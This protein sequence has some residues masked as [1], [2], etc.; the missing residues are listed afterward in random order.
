MRTSIFL[1]AIADS[2]YVNIV[3]LLQAQIN[4]YRNPNND[5]YLPHHLRLSGIANL[6]NTNARTCVHDIASP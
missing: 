1:R 2:E 6:I 5:G 4:A 3:T